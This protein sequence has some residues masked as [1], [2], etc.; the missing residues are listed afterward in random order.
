MGRKVR[1]VPVTWKHPTENTQDGHVP[2]HD[3]FS[4][5]AAKWDELERQWNAG[6]T[7][8]Y[9]TPGAEGFKPKDA[10][11]AGTKFSDYY[12]E[13]PVKSEYMPDWP[14]AE[15][16]HFMMYE[17]CSEGTPISP[18]FETPEEL[19]RWLSDNA[20]SAFGGMTA[21]YEQWLKMIGA[22]YAPSAVFSLEM[23]LTSGVA[24]V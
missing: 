19:A 20:A 1:K 4:K 11:Y 15:R 14:E 2:L 5:D 22:G 21:S 18:A 6:F 13:R 10:K 24:A 23:G 3:G 8:D 16:T 17:T 9:S 12:G 7:T